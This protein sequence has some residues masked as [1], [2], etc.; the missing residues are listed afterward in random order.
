MLGTFIFALV[1]VSLAAY[2]LDRLSYENFLQNTRTDTFLDLVEV[3]QEF[4][5]VHHDHSLSLREMATFIAE[6]PNLSQEEF[7]DK[8]EQIRGGDDFIISIGGAPDLQLTMIYPLDGNEGALGLDYRANPEQLPAIQRMIENRGELVTGPVNLMQ[9]GRGLILRLPVFLAEDDNSLWGV[10]SI[11][12]DF[13]E[14]LVRSGFADAERTYDL[15]I[16]VV[17]KA[18][19]SKN[20]IVYGDPTL[21]EKDA[22]SISLGFEF[23]DWLVHATTKDGW[24]NV[25]PTQWKERALIA[26]ITIAAMFLVAYVLWLSE[27]RKRAELLLQNGIEALPDGFVIFDKQD[28]LIIHNSRYQELYEFPDEALKPG[29]TFGEYV[30]SSSKGPQLLMSDADQA[31]WLEN[32]ANSRKTGVSLDVEQHLQDGRV[33]KASDR[34]MEDGSYVGIRVDVTEL[35]LARET[36]E[37]ANKAKT[38]FMGVLSHELRTPLTVI[39]GVSRLAK[40]ARLLGASKTLLSKIDSG[41]LS[42]DETEK[43]L[44]DVYSQFEKMMDKMIQSGEHLLHLINEMLDVAKIESGSLTIEPKVSNIADITSPVVEQLSSLARQKG[45]QFEVTQ[46]AGTVFADVVRT[47]Q[48]LFNLVGNA[49]KFTDKG[50]V[51]L[52]V[53][54]ESKTVVF[55]VC[56]SGAG[57]PETEL[58]SIFE[59]FYQVDSTET[60]RVGG[61]GMGLTISRNLTKMQ[62]GKLTVKSTIGKGSCFVL[63]LPSSATA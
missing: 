32:R 44:D 45:L 18:S 23:E 12:L 4:Y 54:V 10:V 61:T 30:Y 47:R 42:P 50:F 15:M 40:N 7:A 55:E 11:V 56:D 38:D 51:R 41:D 52:V 49:I 39:L 58:L 28:R 57:I 16:E 36:A 2:R 60:R 3:R 22:V 6:N 17:D 14:F 20:E 19:G 43:L 27:T 63:T 8:A 29:A 9:G 35:T 53:K 24:P 48:I 21:R 33:I 31:E 37:A 5:A 62:G 34:R 1:A 13:E 46:D 26:L 25:S 59:N